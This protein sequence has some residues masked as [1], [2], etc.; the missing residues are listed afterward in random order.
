MQRSNFKLVF[1]LIS[2]LFLPFFA[3]GS[4]PLLTI[5]PEVILSP[6]SGLQCPKVRATD[7]ACLRPS[8]AICTSVR[9]DMA[10]LVNTT[11]GDEVQ[12]PHGPSLKLVRRADNCAVFQVPKPTL[13]LDYPKIL[14]W[15]G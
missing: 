10:L 15:I 2:L 3:E 12:L 14:S 11:V 5:L 13:S 6:C 1:M 9:L 4:P 7:P 8:V